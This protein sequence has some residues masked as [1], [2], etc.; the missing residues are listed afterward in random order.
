MRLF[1][2]ILAAL[3]VVSVTPRRA[4]AAEAGAPA[5][6]GDDVRLLYQVVTCQT[7]PALPEGLDAATVEAYCAQQRPRFQ[8][9]IEHWGKESKEFLAPLQPADLPSEL[10]YPFG[11]GDLMMAL[12]SFP[13]AEVISTISLELAGDPRRLRHVTDK[14]ALKN[15]LLAISQAGAS[16]LMSNDSKSVN[17]SR[18]QRGELPG[19]LSLHLIGLMLSGFVP[20]SA[21]YFKVEADGSLHYYAP[22]E[23][24]AME[25]T[26]AA[27]LHK[28]WSSPDFS[29]AFANVELRFVPAADPN[30][31]PRIFRHFAADLSDE[32]LAKYPGLL[33]HLEQ[34]GKV[35]A[36]TKAASY[37]L[38]RNDFSKIRDYLVGH[39]RFMISDSTGV[40]LRFWKSAG[41]EV[42]TYGW[43]KAPFLGAS[44]A[45]QTEL[46]EAY[47]AQPRRAL[48]M[49]FGYPDGSPDKLSHLLVTDCAPKTASPAP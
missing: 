43:F 15:S 18:I 45:Y 9:F 41:C 29:P 14:T 31:K 12:A 40:P 23:I 28:S 34:K 37:L 48:P 38:W 22:A 36:M 13:K 32:G 47:A 16:T 7:G 35:A 33:A 2:A 46:R 11:G 39:A 17:L 10:V 19:Q 5:E 42:R 3:L 8:R 20:I 26:K 4:R 44:E 6:L 24:E 21:R 1:I 27:S 30:A 49:R 25:A